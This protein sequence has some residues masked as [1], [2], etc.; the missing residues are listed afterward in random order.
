VDADQQ[1]VLSEWRSE[2]AA[3]FEALAELLRAAMD[4][5]A[6]RID[7]IGST[8]VPG[9]WAKDVIDVQVAVP[10]LDSGRIVRALDPLGFAQRTD[11]WNVRDHIPAGWIGNPEAWSKLVFAPPNGFR[12]SNVHVRLKGSP[13]ERYALLFRDFLRSN[14]EI[15]DAWARF[16]TLLCGA[17]RTLSDYGTV[18]DPAT[19]VLIALAD[20]WATE[21]GWKVPES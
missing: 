19:D 7:H 15:R 6:I 11:P 13:N 18:K 4:G 10:E 17:T 16:K 9:L 14:N 20:R 5:F 3:D 2:W 12:P 1:V 8:S 21:T